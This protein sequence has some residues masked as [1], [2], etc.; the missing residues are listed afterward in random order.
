VINICVHGFILTRDTFIMN[1]QLAEIVWFGLVWFGL[2]W[3][4][5]ISFACLVLLRGTNYGHETYCFTDSLRSHRRFLI[6]H[7]LWDS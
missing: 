6:L 2:V 3:F 7:D 1:S 5:G 4:L